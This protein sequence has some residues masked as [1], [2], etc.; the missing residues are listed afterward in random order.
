MHIRQE[1]PSDYEV[2]TEVIQAAFKHDVF[3]DQQEY[4]LVIDLRKSKAYIPE[5]AL[6][7]EI[8]DVVVGHILLT[9]I[10]IEDGS[11]RYPS[12]A[13]APISVHPNYQRR[14]IGRHLIE[15]AHEQA[16]LLGYRSV[17]LVGHADYYPRFGYRPAACFGIQLPFPAPKENCMA[18][19][20]EKGSLKGVKG[21]VIYSK[22]FG[23][24]N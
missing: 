3:S 22:A 21:M 4:Q 17:V 20:L 5:L 15:R 16:R 7:A 6:V 1:Q 13:L 23:L 12:L 11:E 2:L 9:K 24:D 14:G 19:E 18:L 8:D 10:V